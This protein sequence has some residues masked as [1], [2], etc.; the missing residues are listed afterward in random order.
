VGKV[1]RGKTNW[2]ADL[3]LWYAGGFASRRSLAV[4]AHDILIVAAAWLLVYLA[5][6]DFGVTPT[7]WI[8]F[9]RSLPFVLLGQGAVLWYCG[10]YRGIWRFSSILDAWN[11]VR[12]AVLGVL[13]IALLLFL[14]NR[15]EGVPRTVLAAYPVCLILLLGGP[16]LLYRVWSEHG[17]AL[18]NHGEF[19]R[20]L[21]LGAGRAGEALARDMR[22]DARYD[23]VAF[24][25]D[26]V[27]LL[28]SKLHG[29]PVIGTIAQLPEVVAELKIDLVIIAI[30]STNNANMR[31]IV[32]I[33]ERCEVPFRTLPRFHDLS[34][35]EVSVAELRE[36]NIEDLLGRDAVILDWRRIGAY[37][38]GRTILVSG[39]GGSIGS[40]LCRQIARFKP[41]MLVLFESNEC[42]LFYIEAELRTKYPELMVCA[43]LGDVRDASAVARAFEKFRPDMVFHAAAYKHVPML[44]FNLREAVRNNVVGTRIMASAAHDYGCRT[45]VMISTDKAVNSNNVMGATKRIAE[46]C[47][48]AQR[49][50][51]R[52][53]FIT[54]RFGNVLGSAGSV[55]PLF[56]EQIRAGGPVTV[57]HPDMVRYFMTIP[58]AA[59]LIMQA[60]AMGEGG[61][62]FVLDMGD[63]VRIT[64]LAEQMIRLSG[65]TPGVDVKIVYTALRPGE[66]LAEE[67]FH[68]DEERVQTSHSQLIL[69]RAPDN[70]RPDLMEDLRALEAAV[71]AYDDNAIV[72]LMEKLV[73]P[74]AKHRPVQ[75]KVVPIELAKKA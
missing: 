67:L 27:S 11:I 31:R 35:G 8:S 20:V 55:V 57:T 44:E 10:L 71:E 5:R 38:I 56:Q 74:I 68:Q 12:A 61:E 73:P 75:Q 54:V 14:F 9:W 24:L 21:I 29:A 41:A 13:A 30:P 69:A 43:F 64:Y 19:K 26:Q 40:E 42:N 1:L 6:F 7:G 65:K 45:F 34:A 15:L 16:R 47:C 70:E 39:A 49:R 58:E 62:T 25:D 32:E 23:P 36:V 17:F 53:R 37:A 66:K 3:T 18:F 22:R 4:V 63:P 33:C 59:Q 52:T 51:S 28:G 46:L 50:R 72:R 2:S 60:A 48:Q